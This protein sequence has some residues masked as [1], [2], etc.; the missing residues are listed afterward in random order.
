MTPMTTAAINALPPHL[1][2]HGTAMNNTIR[3]VASAIGTALLIM[4]MSTVSKAS[5]HGHLLA[6]ISGFK[7]V[8]IVVSFIALLGIILSFFIEQNKYTEGE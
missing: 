6:M 1:I 2:T 8:Y 3:Q 4:L 7:A 5:T